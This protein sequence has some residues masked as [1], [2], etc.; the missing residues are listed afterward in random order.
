MKIGIIVY[1]QTGNTYSV[2]L[3]LKEKLAAAGHAAEIERVTAT[4]NVSP[5]SKNF[6][7]DTRPAVDSYDALVFAA[8][9]QGFFLSPAMATYLEQLPSL[10][11]KTVACFVTKGLPFYWTGGN[12]AVGRMKKICESKGA[13]VCGTEIVNWNSRRDL[14]I[15]ECV[16]RL[17][18]LFKFKYI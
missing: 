4:G 13:V 6:Q 12:Q 5:G 15:K 11:D 9:V 10:R 14:I 7:L 16:G 3:Q 17:N 1:S 2:A 8:P 18:S